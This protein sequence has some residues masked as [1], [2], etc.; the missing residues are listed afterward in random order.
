MWLGN[1]VMK[2]SERIR[3]VFKGTKADVIFLMNTDV[4]D[5][6]FTYLA[7]FTSGVFEYN[8]L[9]A[10]RKGLILPVS[11]LEYEIAKGQRPKNMRI[12]KIERTKQMEALL[13]KYLKSKVVGIN[14][15]FLPYRY[16]KRLRRTVKP[17]LIIDVSSNFADA[18]SIKDNNEIKR[19]IIANKIARSA[20]YEAK[21]SL[22]AGMTEKE[23]AGRIEYLMMSK[24]ADK[25]SFSTIVAFDR[26]SALPHH[27]PGSTKLS[28][29]SIVLI[30]MGAKYSNYCSDITRTFLFM[31]EKKSKKYLKFAEMY[32]IVY[33]AQKLATGMIKEG[34]KGSDVHNAAANLIN[35]AANGKYKGKFIHSLG[36]S[37]GIDVHDYG[38]GL[39]PGSKDSL[40]E[41]MVV[42]N[43]PGI[44][45]VGFGG[46]RIE[47]DILVTKKGAA[48]L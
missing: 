40:K 15:S 44:Y 27:S 43:E 4:Q 20:L 16:Y 31:P 6:N 11:S 8:T 12:I 36:H 23:V 21:K 18:R 9:I 32:R 29:N 2:N 5:S 22:K 41:G 34:V 46:V 3:K 42:S 7:G 47:D 10:T 48:V 38:P 30:D 37:V 28:R 35:S 14:E 19:I 13:K 26:N 17:K 39:S 25:A 24:G 45:V 33:N 1:D